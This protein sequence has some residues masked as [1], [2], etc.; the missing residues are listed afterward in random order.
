MYIKTCRGN[1]GSLGQKIHFIAHFYYELA[2]WNT[3]YTCLYLYIKSTFETLD[4]WILNTQIWRYLQFTESEK[5]VPVQPRVRCIGTTHEVL[6]DTTWASFFQHKT[7]FIF[8]I[9]KSNM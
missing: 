9:I 7:E 2:I 1:R 6:W 3:Q 4:M 5:N 8:N